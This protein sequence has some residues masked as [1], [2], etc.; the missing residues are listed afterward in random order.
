MRMRTTDR[1]GVS[2]FMAIFMVVILMIFSSMAINISNLQRQHSASQISADLGVHWGVDCLARKIDHDQ[3]LSEVEYLV[4][5]N[6][7][8][9]RTRADFESPNKLETVKVEFGAM[10]GGDF[11]VGKDPLNAIRAKSMAA[12]KL[13][14][15]GVNQ[16]KFIDVA[17]SAVASV[18]EGGGG[19]VCLVI[20]RGTAMTYQKDATEILMDTSGHPY[21]AVAG[22]SFEMHWWWHWPHPDES[23]WGMQT[24]ALYRVAR[25]LSEKKDKELSIVSYSYF[26]DPRVIVTHFRAPGSWQWWGKIYMGSY[27]CK[28]NAIVEAPPTMEYVAAIDKLNHRYRFESPLFGRTDI[29]AGIDAAADLL[30]G[31]SSRSGE[32]VIIVLNVEPYDRGRPPWLAAEDALKQG[33]KVHTIS[34]GPRSWIGQMEKIAL[35]GDGQHIHVRTEDEMVAAIETLM[36]DDEG[37]G[38]KFHQ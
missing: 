27:D 36:G 33:V 26:H 11:V 32:K 30:T 4:Q 34:V 17:R 7:G 1:R 12:V 13:S 24:K 29:G 9:N 22:T 28:E 31:P 21:N 6:T 18:G 10:E 8:P 20:H 38:V 35:F 16:G 23:H 2:A 3:I 19:D 14:G 5:R 15:V 37:D 25:N